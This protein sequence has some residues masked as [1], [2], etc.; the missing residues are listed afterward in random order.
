MKKV[1]IL[2]GD[3]E[4]PTVI[5]DQEK[6]VFEISGISMPEDVF[7]FYEPIMDW[8]NEYKK[9][10]LQ[11]TKFIFKLKYTNT[12]SSKAILNILFILEEINES[13]NNVEVEW[14]FDKYDV[15]MLESGRQYAEIIQ[16]FFDFKEQV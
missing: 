2:H 10:P 5:L 12:A 3:K 15:D 16:L 6:G 14:F 11:N 13:E 4:T 1:F 8:L 9:N 7:A